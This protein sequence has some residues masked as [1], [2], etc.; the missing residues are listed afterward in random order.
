MKLWHA[1]VPFRAGDEGSAGAKTRLAARLDAPARAVL[2]VAMAQHVLATLGGCP[3]LGSITVLAPARPSFAPAGTDWIA[4]LGRGLNP[5]LAAA[6]A[7]TG[8]RQVLVIHADLPLLSASDIAALLAE[9]AAVGAAIAP[10]HARTGTNALALM[11]SG[12]LQPALLPAFGPD[13]LT[14]H[15]ALLPHAAIVNR[16]GLALDIDTP[17]DLDRA[18]AAGL[19]RPVN[20]DPI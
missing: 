11:N 1:I 15:R 13:S 20:A 5:E 6:I 3:L 9:A 7:L 10:D 4:D 19:L 17:A 2:A 8:P 18:I 14:L 16:P 12:A